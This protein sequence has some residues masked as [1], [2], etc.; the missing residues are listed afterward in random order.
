MLIGLLKTF[1]VTNQAN[2]SSFHYGLMKQPDI[3]RSLVPIVAIAVCEQ[4][5]HYLRLTLR[6]LSF[7][8]ILITQSDMHNY[9]HRS[10]L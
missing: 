1:L 8:A 10:T 6:G 2:N 5:F 7:N 9:F 4:L 3:S